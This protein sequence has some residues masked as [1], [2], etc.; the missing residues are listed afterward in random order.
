MS[1]RPLDYP[2][3]PDA[4]PEVGYLFNP[5]TFPAFR[6]PEPASASHHLMYVPSGAKRFEN[7][8]ATIA[9]RDFITCVLTDERVTPRFKEWI[10]PT[11]LPEIVEAISDF[12]DRVAQRR[13]LARRGDLAHVELVP[14][15]KVQDLL[16][17]GHRLEE[18]LYSAYRRGSAVLKA[19]SMYVRNDLGQEWPWLAH[20]LAYHLVLRQWEHAVGLTMQFMFPSKPDPPAP[21]EPLRPT[22]SEGTSH[23][24][25]AILRKRWRREID[26]TLAKRR[27]IG[28]PTWHLP[29]GR[30]RSDSEQNMPRWTRWLYTDL[31]TKEV[32]YQLA[33]S[34]HDEQDDCPGDG[35]ACH[36]CYEQ[37][38][39]GI[40]R[41]L[42]ILNNT[43][44]PRT[45]K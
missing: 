35:P 28:P 40:K 11:G 1:E 16:P 31:T 29:L 25:N 9:R 30:P 27:R 38:R 17:D 45:Q 15:A 4:F 21:G 13:G 6:P 37:V 14:P 22:L 41:A 2:F 12:L 26:E 33:R 18:Y 3:Q 24:T 7:Y 42:T 19:A 23:E 32:R 5:D 34:Y 10:A 44:R 39:Y 20:S 43:S 8:L 36:R